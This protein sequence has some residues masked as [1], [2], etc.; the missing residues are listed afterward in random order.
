MKIK[1]PLTVIIVAYL[2]S[3]SYINI[4]HNVE[5]CLPYRTIIGSEKY[6]KK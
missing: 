1:I 5:E 2:L 6:E 3:F 4:F